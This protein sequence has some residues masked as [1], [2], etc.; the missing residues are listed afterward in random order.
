[1]RTD[2]IYKLTQST[3]WL[4]EVKAAMTRRPLIGSATNELLPNPVLS[5]EALNRLS[6]TMCLGSAACWF[7]NFLEE[8]MVNSTAMWGD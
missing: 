2:A 4:R 1:M 6:S 8:L 3:R 7:P 5:S